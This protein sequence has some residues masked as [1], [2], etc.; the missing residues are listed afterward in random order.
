MHPKLI[1]IGTVLVGIFLVAIPC[2]TVAIVMYDAASST[3][4]VQP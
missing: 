4:Y 2:A 3:E 1:K